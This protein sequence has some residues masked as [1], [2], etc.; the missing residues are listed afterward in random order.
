[1]NEEETGRPPA[2]RA[3]LRFGVR[4]GFD[5]PAAGVIGNVGT[6]YSIGA[7]IMVPVGSVVR[8]HFDVRYERLGAFQ[9]IRADPLVI[10]F[11]IP[12]SR[13]AFRFEIE[14][15]LAALETEMLFERGYAIGLSSGARLTLAAGYGPIFLAFTPGGISVRYFQAQREGVRAAPGI[16]VPIGITAGIEL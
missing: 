1:V 6:A 13:S 15:V 12:I 7:E 4:T 11:A 2:E 10:G 9:G 3:P 5:L 16:N 14:L 8:F